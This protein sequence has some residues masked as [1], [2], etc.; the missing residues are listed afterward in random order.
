MEEEKDLIDCGVSL[1]Y[2]YPPSLRLGPYL[3]FHVIYV[4]LCAEEKGFVY[5]R[6]GGGWPSLPTVYTIEENRLSLA[7]AF[8][9]AELLLL[10]GALPAHLLRPALVFSLPVRRELGPVVTGL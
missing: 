3:A 4:L 5:Q 1:I 7:R 6:R 10:S 9:S 8:S 2:F